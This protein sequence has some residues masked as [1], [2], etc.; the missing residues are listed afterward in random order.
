MNIFMIITAM[1]NLI[2]YAKS[3]QYWESWN[4]IVDLFSLKYSQ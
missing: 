4:N 1:K 3:G 2:E